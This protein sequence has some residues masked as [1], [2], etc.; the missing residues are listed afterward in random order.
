MIFFCDFSSG[1]RE[2]IRGTLA[3]EI[4]RKL[5]LK[6]DDTETSEDIKPQIFIMS[7]P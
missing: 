6:G 5:G 3:S 4:I 2:V 1:G 7:S